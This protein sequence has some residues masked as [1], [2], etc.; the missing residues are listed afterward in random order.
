VRLSDPQKRRRY[1]LGEDLDDGPGMAG[2]PLRSECTDELLQMLMSVTFS[3]CS[4]AWAVWAVWVEWEAWEAWA[5]WVEDMP[6]EAED[7]PMAMT[8]IKQNY[9]VTQKLNSF[10]PLN[11]FMLL[12]LNIVHWCCCDSTPSL[13]TKSKQVNQACF[14][15]MPLF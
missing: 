2:T 11:S 13:C 4:L 15:S 3:T 14:N 10:H 5:V 8:S 12:K 9:H 7:L 6:E 1:D